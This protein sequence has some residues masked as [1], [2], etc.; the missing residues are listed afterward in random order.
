[1]AEKPPSFTVSDRRKF[2][3]EG[4]LRDEAAPSPE[5]TTP[6]APFTAEAPP[7]QPA[8]GP[9][10]VTTPP[11]PTEEPEAPAEEEALPEPTAQESADQHA[12]YQQS[13]RE[14][15]SMLL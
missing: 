5:T 13:S 1:M 4:E 9:R 2:T 3:L 11:P 10:L 7:A 15:D 14:L 8:P 6:E 12:A